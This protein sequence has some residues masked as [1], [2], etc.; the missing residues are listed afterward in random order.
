MAKAKQRA[1]GAA[2]KA[3]G[4]GK[5][6]SKGR[7]GCKK[8][9]P[10]CKELYEKHQKTI[11]GAKNKELTPAQ[12]ADLNK[13]KANYEANKSRYEA[14]GNE[15]NMPPELVASLHW[16]ESSG[17]FGTYLHQGDPLGKPATHVPTDIPVF[18]KDEWD[19]AAAHALK[20]KKWDKCKEELGLNKDTK[21]KAKMAAFSERYNGMGYNNKGV[22][23]PYVYSGTDAYT[24]GKYIADGTYS[25]TAVDKQF[26]VVRLV[27]SIQ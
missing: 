2:G 3:K 20:M 9:K 14:V 22:A 16:R 17:N 18:G 23:S 4:K 19:K 21:D 15:A 25:A 10:T 13:F 5:G 6:K 24:S 7:K 11:E 27:D 1:K 8:C 26:G 12:Q